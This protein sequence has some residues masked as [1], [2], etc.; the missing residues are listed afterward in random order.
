MKTLWTI[1]TS[2]LKKLSTSCL[3]ARLHK[4]RHREWKEVHGGY[5][6]MP[7]IKLTKYWPHCSCEQEYVFLFLWNYNVS[8]PTSQDSYVADTFCPLY[9]HK[10]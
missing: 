5:G 10:E 9:T 4:G 1:N 8:F 6:I 3:H 2:W 7:V